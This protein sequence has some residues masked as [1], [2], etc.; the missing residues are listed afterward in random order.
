MT[1]QPESDTA[2]Q[3][4]REKL[5]RKV[6]RIQLALIIVG[7]ILGIIASNID[8]GLFWFAFL[9]GGFGA[10]V[11]LLRKVT[12][13]APIPTYMSSGSTTVTIA[14][15][16]YG[17]LLASVV[18]FLMISGIVSGEGGQGL[19]VSNLF[20]NFD[21]GTGSSATDGETTKQTLTAWEQFRLLNPKTVK[22][23]GKALVWCFVG[24]Y[25]ESFVTGM[26]SS[27]EGQGKKQEQE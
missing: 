10:S 6:L 20:P 21:P 7:S 25:S 19:L 5:L 24:G 17:A 11:A 27:L 8:I 12:T 2:K 1:P 26:L 4:I 23:A 14:P 16:L 15:V 18:Y 9:G 22:D 13:N 3:V